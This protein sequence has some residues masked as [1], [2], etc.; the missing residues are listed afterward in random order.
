MELLLQAGK[1]DHRQLLCGWRQ[2]CNNDMY[3]A[4]LAFFQQVYCRGQVGPALVAT[5]ASAATDQ[6]RI[7]GNRQSFA[8][9]ARGLGI[10]G[11]E[12]QC[13]HAVV[14]GLRA[15]GPIGRRLHLQPHVVANGNHLVRVVA[16]A[17]DVT[18][19]AHRFGVVLG[20]HY[21]WPD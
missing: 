10:P 2:A 18:K 11:T 14:D 6:Q 17:Q 19:P 5:C 15:A 4:A 13:I 3:L 20:Q 16:C 12:R 7:V 8:L 21:A 9:D 1:P